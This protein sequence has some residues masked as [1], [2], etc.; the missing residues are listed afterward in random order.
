[1]R[2]PLRAGEEDRHSMIIGRRPA[3]A[4]YQG[5]HASGKLDHERDRDRRRAGPDQPGARRRRAPAIGGGVEAEVPTIE[6]SGTSWTSRDLAV[7]RAMCGVSGRDASMSVF[8]FDD[9][10]PQGLAHA[11]WYRIC[12]TF[13]LIHSVPISSKLHGDCRSMIVIELPRRAHSSRTSSRCSACTRDSQNTSTADSA[14]S[15]GSAR[16]GREAIARRARFWTDGDENLQP[17]F[18]WHKTPAKP[19]MSGKR[20]VPGA[21]V[22]A[23]NGS[24][25]VWAVISSLR[26]VNR[27]RRCWRQVAAAERARSADRSPSSLRS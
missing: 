8:I 7:R 11:V 25:R 2:R 19:R 6:L 12:G 18:H 24:P 23:G 20:L 16:V 21:Q 13:M 3:P 15:R 26:W 1:M 4:L 10:V 9:G 27:E 22:S 14:D 5:P 17:S